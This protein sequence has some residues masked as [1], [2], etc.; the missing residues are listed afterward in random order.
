M[1]LSMK[2][3][4]SDT[5][6]P[7]ESSTTQDVILTETNSQA[8]TYPTKVKKTLKQRILKAILTLILPLVL[9]Y[10]LIAFVPYFIKPGLTQSLTH[11]IT[12]IWTASS[13]LQFGIYVMI[14]F[15]FFPKMAN[16]KRQIAY[17]H[18]VNMDEFK[19]E[20]LYDKLVEEDR[21]EFDADYALFQRQIE[22]LNQMT[23]RRNQWIVMGICI[24]FDLLAGQLPFWLMT[25]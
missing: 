17:D 19:A 24:V 14:A 1:N 16:K 4:Q 20:G 25:R 23:C 15:Y 8:T 21:A 6:K 11:M 9:I 7:I 3:T 5:E 12:Q 13:I 2:P 18:L 22:K 10:V